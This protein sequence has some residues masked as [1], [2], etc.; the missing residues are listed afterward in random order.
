MLSGYYLLI[1]NEGLLEFETGTSLSFATEGVKEAT[2][3]QTKED[4]ILL[5]TGKRCCP[6]QRNTQ[7]ISN[8]ARN[9]RKRLK[10]EDQSRRRPDVKKCHALIEGG[11]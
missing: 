6:N 9:S 8:R 4:K 7:P 10:I 3:E 5:K 2:T 1:C 11:V